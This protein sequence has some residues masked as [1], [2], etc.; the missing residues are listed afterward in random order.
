MNIWDILELSPTTDKKTIK[1]AYAR[2]AKLCHPEEKPEE[3]RQLYEAYQMALAYADRVEAGAAPG[4]PPEIP[5]DF[6][7][8]VRTDPVLPELVPPEQ[9]ESPLDEEFEQAFQDAARARQ[10]AEEKR[11]RVILQW[12]EFY[13]N[14]RNEQ[15]YQQWMVFVESDEFREIS[16]DR[17]LIREILSCFQ[18]EWF[19]QGDIYEQMW[20]VYRFDQ[21]EPEHDQDELQELYKCLKNKISYLKLSQKQAHKNQRQGQKRDWISQVAAVFFAVVVMG[22]LLI[23]VKAIH[24]HMENVDQRMYQAAVDHLAEQYPF[25]EFTVTEEYRRFGEDYRGYTGYSNEYPNVGSTVWVKKSERQDGYAAVD[26]Y[27][28]DMFCLYAGEY[29]LQCVVYRE[30]PD[31][32]GIL[33]FYY[34]GIDDDEAELFLTRFYQFMDSPAV[35]RFDIEIRIS[36]APLGIIFPS[37]MVAGNS[38][39]MIGGLEYRSDNLPEAEELRRRITETYLSYMYNYESWNLSEDQTEQYIDLFFDRFP[40]KRPV[41]P[42]KHPVISIDHIKEVFRQSGYPLHTVWHRDELRYCMTIGNL[43]YYLKFSG[44]DIR[45]SP[46]GSGFVVSRDGQNY[47]FGRDGE[48]P[49]VEVDFAYS[50]TEHGREYGTDRN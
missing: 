18:W 25:V 30:Q 31:A 46:D 14:R 13:K 17:A 45:V 9:S 3:F 37:M 32:E 38:G 21:S 26:D 44:A 19:P 29:D 20:K 42:V 7:K 15:V 8:A 33:M 36:F 27:W 23:A 12:Q 5:Q 4:V 47:V 39:D 11:D 1:R 6:V 50:L 24:W 10:E 2:L 49:E 16:A 43:Y 41:I 34:P 35:K 40:S 28:E 48:Y 22:G